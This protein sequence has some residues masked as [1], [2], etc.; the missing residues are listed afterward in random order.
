MKVLV[1]IVCVAIAVSS[2]FA[3]GGQV[4]AV[5]VPEVHQI[6]SIDPTDTDFSDL[7]ALGAAIGDA[8][9]VMLG[10]AGHGDGSAFL[11]KTRVISY[12]HE[13]LG[14]N[15][16]A[17]ESGLY[18]LFAARQLVAD[19][20]APG[21]AVARAV[22]PVWAESDQFQPLLRYLTAQH[23]AGTPLHAAGFDLQLSGELGAGLPEAL[24]RLNTDLPGDD[25]ALARLRDLIA[26]VLTEGPGVLGDTPVD[27]I[28]A[29]V[30]TTV[31][32]LRTSSL[33]EREWWAQIMAST[34]AF[35][36]FLHGLS[37]PT[38]GVLNQ[39]DAQMA[40]NLSWLANV[41]YPDEKIIV[42]GASSHLL[43]ERDLEGD[44]APGMRPMGEAVH[45]EFGDGA[46]LLAFTAYQGASAS[47]ATRETTDH[48]TAPSGS[49]EATLHQ[50]G[51]DYA[52]VAT[53]NLA[54]ALPGRQTS[55]LLGY[56]PM[57]TAWHRAVDGI[58]FI[59]TMEPSTFIQPTT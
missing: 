54:R 11:A 53:D 3:T 44:P 17:F 22:F 37:D 21:A 32:R 25:P 20:E 48:G 42:W 27:Q 52:F 59:D 39:R 47:Y 2:V 43:R 4:L 13:H 30:A 50:S 14:F 46:Y 36:V 18:D 57:S 9:I 33:P 7:A 16:I 23:Q 35:L 58:F 51:F 12:L 15:V 55:W 41:A 34:G 38:P 1:V 5:E 49:I 29:D 24:D 26:A 8:R 6:R 28:E 40:A 19:S 31:H 56:K 10:E 45:R